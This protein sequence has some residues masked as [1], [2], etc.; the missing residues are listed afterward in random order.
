MG[1]LCIGQGNK[2]VRTFEIDAQ[3]SIYS[4]LQC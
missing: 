1:S 4:K 2:G 3:Q